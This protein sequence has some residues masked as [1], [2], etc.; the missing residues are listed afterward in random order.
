MNRRGLACGA[1]LRI[2][3]G[4]SYISP[5]ARVPANH[6]LRKIRELVRNVPSE[7]N[8]DLGK[9]TQVKDVPRRLR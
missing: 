4:F 3:A 5:E 8:P 1:L 2:R 7:M 6:P 9:L